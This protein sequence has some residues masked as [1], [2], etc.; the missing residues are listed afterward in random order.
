MHKGVLKHLKKYENKFKFTITLISILLSLVVMIM[1][2]TILDMGT[3]ADITQENA[4][5]S[6]LQVTGPDALTDGPTLAPTNDALMPY[7]QY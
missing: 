3:L 2:L 1:I 4:F 6:A 5:G 7:W